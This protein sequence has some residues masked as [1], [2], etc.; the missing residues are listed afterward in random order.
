M[1]KV[2]VF[3]MVLSFFSLQA[4][5]IETVIQKG[6]DAAL[7]SLASDKENIFLV[8]GS[9]DNTAKLWNIATGK[10]IRTYSGHEESIT[11]VDISFN[12]KFVAT[13]SN[14]GTAKVWETSSGKEVFSTKPSKRFLYAVLFSLDGRHLVT[15]GYQDSVKVWNIESGKRIATFPA[16]HKINLRISPDGQWLA[17]GESNKKLS[18][19]NTA[20]WEVHLKQTMSEGY[21]GP[22]NVHV[23]FRPDSK[24][25]IKASKYAAIQEFD[26]GSGALLR[27]FGEEIKDNLI[28]LAFLGDTIVLAKETELFIYGQDKLLTSMALPDQ[29]KISDVQVVQKSLYVASEDNRAYCFSLPEL[30]KV[31]VYEGALNKVDKGNIKYD[32]NNYWDSHIAKYIRLKNELLLTRDGRSIMKGKTGV[33][34]KFWD[35]ATGVAVKEY[36]GH[37]SAVLC[38]A[39]SKDE[40]IVITGDASGRA[41]VW[42][43]EGNNLLDLYGHREPIFSIKLSPDEK[44]VSI[45]SW[46]AIISTWNLK[47]GERVSLIDLKRNAAYSLSYTTDGLYLIAGRLGKSLEMWEPDSKTLVKTFIGHTDVVSSIDFHPT[48][49]NIMLTSSWDGSI[50]AW[51][52]HTGLMVKKFITGSPVQACLF[53]MDG[54]S[55]ITAG[56]DRLVKIWDFDTGRLESSLEGHLT[57]IT[58]LTLS[59]DGKMLVSVGMDGIIKF[60]N[61]EKRK[62]FYEHLTLGKGDWM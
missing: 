42:D 11:S 28:G 21:C 44:Y 1:K 36:T 61:F 17:I 31:M 27:T 19:I 16:E 59:E 58:N 13:A 22:C 7:T 40:K 26:V 39:K 49:K 30:K 35:I 37:E 46:D 10:E 18:L 29:S 3:S 8:T 34:A 51:D 38:F 2:L 48:R 15:A 33:V 6:H 9:R 56:N 45:S 62:E 24:T 32:I 12:K 20:S 50:R 52:I 57:E 14:D 23:A 25:F 47:T 4:Q 53:S 60:W 41:K 55:I 54:R 5:K 43:S